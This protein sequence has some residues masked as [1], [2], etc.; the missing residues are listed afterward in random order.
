MVS[1]RNGL[2]VWTLSLA[3]SRCPQ[4]W[5]CRYLL[6]PVSPGVVYREM[7]WDGFWVYIPPLTPRGFLQ[8]SLRRSKAWWLSTQALGCADHILSTA[9]PLGYPGQITW[10]P[11]ISF[12]MCKTGTVIPCVYQREEAEALFTAGFTGT[13]TQRKTGLDCPV[14]LRAPQDT[15]YWVSGR[16]WIP[17]PSTSGLPLTHVLLDGLVGANTLFSLRFHGVGLGV[18]VEPGLTSHYLCVKGH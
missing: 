1:N 5:V 8:G 17:D 16:R 3:Q 14:T 6:L 13:W 10:L 4:E 11:I 7:S 9:Q 15:Q 18:L 12:L 2:K